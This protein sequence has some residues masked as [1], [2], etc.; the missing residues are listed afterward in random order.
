MESFVGFVIL[1]VGNEI[2][3]FIKVGQP[4]T[5]PSQEVNHQTAGESFSSSRRPVF[6]IKLNIK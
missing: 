2:V 5:P 6:N 1:V 3:Y 4:L